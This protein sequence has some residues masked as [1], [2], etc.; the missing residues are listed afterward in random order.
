MNPFRSIKLLTILAIAL[1]AFTQA[2]SAQ[3]AGYQLLTEAKVDS[4]GIFL[5]QL[6]APNPAVVLPQVRLAS[7]P[8]LGQTI[9]LSRQQIC[10]LLQQSASDL[11]STNWTGAA[12][13]RISRRTRQ[14]NETE[15]TELL[16]ST[17]QREYVK[18]CGELEIHSTR[19]WITVLVPD[20][21]LSAKITDL[22]A[23]GVN[24]NF[25]LRF[26]LWNGRERVG[27]WQLPVQAKVWHDIPV[28]HSALM[29]GQ[30]LVD[31][32]II[33]ERRDVLLHRDV[34]SAYPTTDTS[35]ELTENLQV[36]MPVLTRS[37]RMKPIIQRG[38]IIEALYQSGSL[39]I[40]LKVEALEDGL[41]GQTVRVR[42]PKTRRELYG[43]VQNEQTVIIIL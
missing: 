30:R 1:L 35:F 17:L 40:S 5:N 36:G 43:K 31:A 2:S 12:Q 7:A 38:K 22:P 18:D 27:A 34:F 42:N 29:R 6:V 16:T 33:M 25:V 39:S 11:V 3:D 13:V 19:N 23:T 41:P 32:D 8:A 10:D 4:T 9:T 15:I 20:E 28:A 14:L 24:P 21:E 26:E 37:V